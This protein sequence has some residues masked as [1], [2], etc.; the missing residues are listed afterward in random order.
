MWSH[1]VIA[2]M[3]AGVA[4]LGFPWRLSR[5]MT[6]PR[7]RMTRFEGCTQREQGGPASA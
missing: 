1:E 6:D 5:D 3:A 7:E 4:M 2:I